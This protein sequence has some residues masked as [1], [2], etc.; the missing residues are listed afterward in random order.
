MEG[1]NNYGHQHPLLLILNEDQLIYNQSGVTHCSRCGEKVSAPCFCCVDHCGFYLH[2]VCA[3]AP[4][5]LNHPFHHDHPLLLMD[6]HLIT[7]PNYS[8]GYICNFCDEEDNKFV[9]HCSCCELDLHIKCAMFTFNIAENN[10]KELDHVTLQ[11][12]LISTENGDEQLEDDSKCFGCRE[13]LAKYTHFSPDCGFNLHEKCAELPFELN[14]VCHREH[15]L[16]LQFYSEQFYSE[17]ISC[18]ICCRRTRPRGFVYGC[19]PCKFVVHIE[20]ASQSPLQ[21]IKSTNHEHPFTLFNGHQHPLFLMLNQ[22][23]LMDNQRGVT[24]CSR[25]GE[26][27]SAPCFCCAEHCGFYIHKV[28]AKAPLELNHPFHLNHPLLMQ[29]APYS[30]GMY[31]CNFCNKSGHK[32]VYRCSSCELDFHIKCA[33]FTF[34]IAENNLKQLEHVALQ[35]PLIP[36]ENGDEKLKDVFN[37][38]GCREPLANYTRFSPCRGFNLHEKCTEIP[39]KL[40]HVWHRK[41]PLVLQFNS[42]GLSCKICCQVTMRRGFVYGCSPCKFVVHIE[43]ASQSPLKVIKSTNHEHPFTLLLR[44]V[45]FTCD[46]CGTE[47]N[48]VAYSCG[49]CNIIIHKNCISLPRIIKSKWHDHR[50]L[51]TYFHHIEDFRVLNCLICHDEVNTEHGSYYCSKCNGIFHVKCALKDKDSYEIVENEDEIEMPNESSIIVIESND[52]GEATKIKHFKHM[53]NLMLGPFVG[54]YENSCDRCMLPISD[55]FYYCSECVFSLH[56]ACAELPKMKNVWHHDCKEPLAL[57]SDKVFMCQQCWHISNAFAYEC[58]GCERKICLRCVIALIPGARTCLKHEHPLFYYTKH[59]GKCNACGGTTH[60]A[61]CCKDCD[62]VLHLRCFSLPITARHKCDEHLLSLT[63]HDDNSYSEHHY[64][65]ICEQS[66]NSN[67]WFYNCATC[68]TSAHVYCVLR[69]YPFLKLRSIYEKNDHP[70]PLTF[71]MK[72]YYYPDCDKCDEPC[73][74]MAL[75]CSK[76]ECKFIVHWDCVVPTSLWGW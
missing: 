28:C 24:D 42:E 71:V 4:L 7:K 25:C 53:H 51:H 50:L 6:S 38:F 39:F 9:Y 19:S 32:S 21:V 22:E 30:S 54:G 55:P 3:E 36:S 69:Q 74:G 26:K 58:C 18:E 15:P 41:H 64:C 46:G 62:F 57:I 27:V 59:N 68:D 70:H 2:K 8:S 16:V 20:C 72:K 66:R 47:G 23:Q 17:R 10:L 5:E 34:N 14:L 65:D 11:H 49:A 35:H 40:N 1:S 75:E 29:N 73:E 48:H 45:P 13:P 67:R 44:Q 56:K 12:P 52:A 60:G 76:S 61:F 63:H 33:L 37:C 31:I 43:C